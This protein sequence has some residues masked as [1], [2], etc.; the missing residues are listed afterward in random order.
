[1]IIVYLLPFTYCL[2]TLYTQILHSVD[3]QEILR[4]AQNDRRVK[5]IRG[6]SGDSHQN[7]I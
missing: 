1:M 5:N 6:R 7:N 2:T 3:I 4:S